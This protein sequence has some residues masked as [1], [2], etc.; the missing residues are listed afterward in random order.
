MQ[1]VRCF[2]N[3]EGNHGMCGTRLVPAVARKKREARFAVLR[4]L[5]RLSGNA[6]RCVCGWQ[7]RCSIVRELHVYGSVVPVSA[8]DP[9][10][11]Q[12]QGFGTLLMEEAARIAKDEHGSSKLA[13]ISGESPTPLSPPAPFPSCCTAPQSVAGLDLEGTLLSSCIQRWAQLMACVC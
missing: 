8:R 12:H 7:G 10:K 6:S 5:L 1:I 11:F 13:V 2:G 4:R 3:H 9:G